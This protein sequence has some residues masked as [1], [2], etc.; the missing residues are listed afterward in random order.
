MRS[1]LYVNKEE[2]EKLEGI[3]KLNIPGELKVVESLSVFFPDLKEAVFEIIQSSTG[4]HLT[5]VLWFDGCSVSL[6]TRVT[7]AGEYSFK[8]N[9]KDYIVEIEEKPLAIL[10]IE[11]GIIFQEDQCR[12]D[13]IIVEE[14]LRQALKQVEQARNAIRTVDGFDHR[15]SQARRT[16]LDVVGLLSNAQGAYGKLRGAQEAVKALDG[17]YHGK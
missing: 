10:Q 3:L 7:V 14:Q 2:L 15:L 1:T 5:A 13:L 4:T 16:V 6:D 9:D 17:C 8:V 11:S 12:D